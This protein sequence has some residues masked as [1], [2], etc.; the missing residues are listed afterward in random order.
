MITLKPGGEKKGGE[1]K[2]RRERGTRE[3]ST[4]GSEERDIEKQ[5][6]IFIQI[7]GGNARTAG[8]GRKQKEGERKHLGRR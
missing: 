6:H 8:E 1:S 5:V 4:C 7:S 3:F 2:R